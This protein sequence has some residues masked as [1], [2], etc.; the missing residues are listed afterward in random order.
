MDFCLFS[1]R[2]PAKSGKLD[3]S[4][5]TKGRY[6]S[7]ADR[8]QDCVLQPGMETVMTAYKTFFER[9]RSTGDISVNLKMTVLRKFIYT[10]MHHFNSGAHHMGTTRMS[11]QQAVMQ[12]PPFTL[13]AHA[14]RLADH[15]NKND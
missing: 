6:R 13:A 8:V 14:V 12:I 7:S 11:F 9:V 4:F 3:F 10:K 15:L 2:A 1:D 5:E